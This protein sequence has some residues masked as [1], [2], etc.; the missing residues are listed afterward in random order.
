MFCCNNKNSTRGTHDDL[1]AS[2]KYDPSI[3]NNPTSDTWS[4]HSDLDTAFDLTTELSTTYYSTIQFPRATTLLHDMI[5][6]THMN[7]PYEWNIYS[8]TDIVDP[9]HRDKFNT[10]PV[11]LVDALTYISKD[12]TATDAAIFCNKIMDK[13][14]INRIGKLFASI[15]NSYCNHGDHRNHYDNRITV[16]YA[17]PIWLCLERDLMIRVNKHDQDARNIAIQT[18]NARHLKFSDGMRQNIVNLMSYV[19]PNSNEFDIDY[20]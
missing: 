11:N 13:F 4:V 12:W 19:P 14:C 15:F 20:I 7:V 1:Y 6:L 9:Y 8:N 3:Y 17:Y 5:V 10:Y 18:F 2:Y 16:P